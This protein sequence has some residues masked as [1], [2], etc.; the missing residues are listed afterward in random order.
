MKAIRSRALHVMAMSGLLGTASTMAA[1]TIEDR[2]NV[3]AAAIASGAAPAHV[4]VEE[5]VGHQLEAPMVELT[6]KPVTVAPDEAYLVAVSAGVD[7][8]GDPIVL[9][10][11]SFYPPPRE[12]E[13][14]TFLIDL[15]SSVNTGER[16]EL[17]VGLVPASDGSSID[18]SAVEV[19]GAQWAQ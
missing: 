10:T 14:R 9:D 19:T 2:H 15:P 16:I 18:S 12:G 8:K 11:V 17:T 3:S 5:P 1:G 13:E 6:L 4:H 7:D